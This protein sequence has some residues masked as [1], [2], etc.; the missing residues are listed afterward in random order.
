[1]ASN[2]NP[3]RPRFTG[4]EFEKRARL[5]VD[6]YDV[7]ESP[8]MKRE[9]CILTNRHGGPSI[10]VFVDRAEQKRVSFCLVCHTEV[11]S[12]DEANRIKM[13]GGPGHWLGCKLDK[14]HKGDCLVGGKP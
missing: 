4:I 12:Q 2:L 8:V 13:N 11:T 6:F 3:P 9:G 14:N 7:G 1:M 5:L 10:S